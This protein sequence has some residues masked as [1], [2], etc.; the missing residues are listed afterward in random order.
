MKILKKKEEI[1]DN[2]EKTKNLHLKTINQ[3]KSKDLELSINNTQN[4]KKQY[5]NLLDE[6]KI[7]Y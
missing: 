2:F 5:D 1:I 4:L 3:L 6:K 7:R